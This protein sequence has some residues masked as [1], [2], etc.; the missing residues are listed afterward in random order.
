MRSGIQSEDFRRSGI[1]LRRGPQEPPAESNSG[2]RT[3]ETKK[4]A[5]A[6]SKILTDA[7]DGAVGGNKECMKNYEQHL[8]QLVVFERAVAKVGF[9]AVKAVLEAL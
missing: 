7:F 5:F 3:W 1:S 2:R 9:E 8:Y 6:P 4:A